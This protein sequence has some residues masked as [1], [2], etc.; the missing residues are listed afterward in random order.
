MRV[1]FKTLNNHM[2][3]VIGNR[4]S[5]LVN[6][7]EQLSSG[8][9]LLR[10]SDD[11]IDTSNSLQLRSKLAQLKQY[12][13]NI[14]DG[15]SFM[16]VSD[17]AMISMNDL[18]QR[19]RELAIQADTDTLTGDER[20]FIGAEAEQLIRQM[21]TLSNTR[22]KGD[23]VFAGTH[24]RTA[25]YRLEKSAGGSPTAYN[26]REM[27]FYDGSTGVGTPAQF[28]D[29]TNPSIQLSNIIP[30]SVKITVAGVEYIEGTDYTINY[31][32]GTITPLHPDL[33]VDVSPGAGE[34]QPGRFDIRF[35]YIAQAV[36][37]YNDPISISGDILRE[38]EPGVTMPI[39]V[40]GEELVHDVRTGT[41]LF[42]TIIRLGQALQTNERPVIQQSIGSIDV[43]FQNILSAQ[44]KNGARMNRFEL[45]LDRN[46]MQ[47][48]E[49]TRL[50]SELEDA[51]FADTVTKFS[52]AETVYNAALK[53]A[54]RII[55]PSLANFL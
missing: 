16:N 18:M 26:G 21:V 14:E 24:T 33:A 38:I 20:R 27:A 35:D 10:P 29:G 25:P 22:F 50:Q 40:S 28:L 7:Q 1:T 36:D 39:N 52:L 42:E 8:K 48:T 54:G 47:T 37:I 32:D 15:M 12:K 30:G 13:K 11:P 34:Y 31:A 23:Y 46:D 43:S 49:T 3:Y 4:Y 6:L 45:T 51:D 5:D 44:A 55:Q 9:R 53:S 2:Q 41:D 17:T 19:L